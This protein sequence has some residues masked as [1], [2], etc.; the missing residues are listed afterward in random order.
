MRGEQVSQSQH[1]KG[2]SGPSC[3]ENVAE[4]ATSLTE[5]KEHWTVRM[6]GP[7]IQDKLQYECDSVSFGFECI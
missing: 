7:I 6:M 4:Q 5:S 2:V 3:C 1:R